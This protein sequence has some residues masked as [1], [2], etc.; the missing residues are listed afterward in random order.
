MNNQEP[1]VLNNQNK[2]HENF[3]F[4]SLKVLKLLLFYTVKINNK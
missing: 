2:I 4:T 3:Y 1:L